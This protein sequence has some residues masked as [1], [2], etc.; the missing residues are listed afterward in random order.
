MEFAI[1]FLKWLLLT[2]A[3]LYLTWRLT[4]G[5]QRRW[6]RYIPRAIALALAFTPTLVP[7]WPLEGTWP[8]P[9]GWIV[10][11]AIV[12]DG[13]GERKLDLI[14]GGIPLLIV[15]LVGWFFLMLLTRPGQ[16]PHE[17]ENGMRR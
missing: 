8:L 12:L 4:E 7:L 1:V 6:L 14:H 9:A 15:S 2:G 11:C 10:F 3:I 5:V 13:P 17:A 16:S